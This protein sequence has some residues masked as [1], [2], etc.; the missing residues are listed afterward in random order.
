MERNF[1]AKEYVYALFIGHQLIEKLLKALCA[2]T[3]GAEVPRTH[4]LAQLAKTAGIPVSDRQRELM[5]RFLA[6]SLEARYP[7]QRMR[8]HKKA[9]R[10]YTGRQLR[11]IREM[12]D[13]LLDLLSKSLD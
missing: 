8:L 11:Y 6:F 1:R 2:R 3:M 12:R 7:D 5:D 4:D 13:W 9:T 10:E